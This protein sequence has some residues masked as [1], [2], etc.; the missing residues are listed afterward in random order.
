MPDH[1][2]VESKL[3][4]PTCGHKMMETP[5]G[6]NGV[7]LECFWCISEQTT[8]EERLYENHCWRCKAPISSIYC[9][10]AKNPNDGYVC[11]VCGADLSGLR[12]E[13]V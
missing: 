1:A 8:P 3:V 2:S 13:V 5:C 11:V 6:K 12:K 10:R 4:C 7:I 9:T